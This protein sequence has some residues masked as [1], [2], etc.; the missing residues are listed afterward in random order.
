M[1]N[2]LENSVSLIPWKVRSEIKNWPFIAPL[3]RWLLSKYIE[4]NEFT[5]TVD[6]GPAKG[7]QYPITL[8]ADKGIWTGTY[9]LAFS[10]AI[11]KSVCPG[12]VTFDIGAWR[13]FFSGV[14]ALA[15]A[16]KV[17]AFEPLPDN[18][19]Q[20][21]KVIQLNPNLNISLIEAA[22]S[23]KSGTLEFLVM[24]ETSMGKLVDSSFQSGIDGGKKLTINAVKLDDLIADN[25]I[26]VPAVMKIDVEGAELM[27]LKGAEKLLS[28]AKP[29]LFIEIHS[30]ELC[31][32]CNSL[33]V[34]LGYQVLVME[35]DNNPDGFTEPEV[36]HFVAKSSH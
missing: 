8:P 27:V 3:Q 17:I 11:A 14:M 28:D 32:D 24:P 29:T 19:S 20:L 30:R 9:E 22:V 34:K 5:H 18:I 2:V 4:G 35:T 21:K 31:K 7:L 33:L 23:D 12:D 36:C 16:S 26:S 1:K 25:T 6:A 15:G 10:E 13:G